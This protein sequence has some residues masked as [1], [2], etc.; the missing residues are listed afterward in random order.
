MEG[1]I[2]LEK[3][4]GHGFFVGVCARKEREQNGG[5]HGALHHPNKGGRDKRRRTEEQEG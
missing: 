2:K 3:R 5:G 4:T 1:H